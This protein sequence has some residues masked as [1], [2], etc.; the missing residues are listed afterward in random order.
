M[1]S[2][3]SP[4][5]LSNLSD[6]SYQWHCNH[7]E[8]DTQ[9]YCSC[10][11]RHCPVCQDKARE[12]WLLKRQADVLPVAYH[13]VVFTLPHQFNGWETL[14]KF[15]NARH[16]MEGQ[17]G[18]LAV[19]HTWGQTLCRHIHLHCLIPSGVLTQDK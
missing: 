13:H 17:L 18:M 8:Q 2:V 5:G 9:W 6:G 10:R 1:A 11:D 12:K 7:C 14:S 16:H 4:S 15:A 3:A 19:L